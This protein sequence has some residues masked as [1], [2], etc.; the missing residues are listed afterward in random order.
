MANPHPIQKMAEAR[1][2]HQKDALKSGI[3]GSLVGAGSGFIVSAA[4]NSLSKGNIGTWGVFTRTGSTIAGFTALCGVYTFSKDASAN[5][6]EKD[7][8]F[9]AAIGGFLG[10]ATWALRSMPPCWSSLSVLDLN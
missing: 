7:D 5:L 1:V 3:Q 4:Q 10:G 9:N 6:R 2:F 8:S